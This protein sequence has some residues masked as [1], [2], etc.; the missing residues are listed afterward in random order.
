MARNNRTSRIDKLYLSYATQKWCAWD[1]AA[2]VFSMMII[3]MYGI[4]TIVTIIC[5]VFAR[6][7]T[8]VLNYSPMPMER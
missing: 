4:V 1:L 5:H 7:L 3:C 2:Y 6:V 8:V